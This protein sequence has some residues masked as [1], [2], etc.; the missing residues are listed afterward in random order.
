MSMVT[1]PAGVTM[2]KKE[3]IKL[4]RLI[5]KVRVLHNF[6]PISGN[7]E[8]CYGMNLGMC[9][10]CAEFKILPSAS[11]FNAFANGEL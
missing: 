6:C 9:R 8:K 3:K 11:D 4:A 10:G 7:N 5:V 1:S 2:T